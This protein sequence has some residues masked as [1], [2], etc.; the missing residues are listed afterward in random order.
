MYKRSESKNACCD[1]AI[2]YKLFAEANL[3]ASQ[4]KYDL[5]LKYD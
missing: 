2:I 1:N 4:F 3:S 5:D